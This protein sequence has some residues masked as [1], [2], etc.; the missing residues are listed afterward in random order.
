MTIQSP[1]SA[2]F[3]FWL[4]SILDVHSPHRKRI[5]QI[6]ATVIIL[7]VLSS[8]AKFQILQTQ[9]P[10]PEFLCEFICESLRLILLLAFP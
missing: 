5:A 2:I 4:I 6:L 3:I 8:H 1:A 9:Y 10:S 7:Q